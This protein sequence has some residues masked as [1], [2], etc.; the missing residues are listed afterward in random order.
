L[1]NYDFPDNV[2]FNVQVW[3]SFDGL[4]VNLP[5]LTVNPAKPFTILHFSENNFDGD[6]QFVILENES[7]TFSG[8]RLAI[9]Q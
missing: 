8:I 4:I 6:S 9:L 1:R 2:K 7:F 5:S 3:G